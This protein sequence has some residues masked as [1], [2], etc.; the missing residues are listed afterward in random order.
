MN[1]PEESA[2]AVR[3]ARVAS[4]SVVESVVPRLSRSIE[5]IRA[6]HQHETRDDF[7]LAKAA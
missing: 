2:G 6:R 4:L 7:S 5:T 1:S 3:Q